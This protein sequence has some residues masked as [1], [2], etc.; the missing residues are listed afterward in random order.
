[1]DYDEAVE[2]FDF[3]IAAAYVGPGTPIFME[4]VREE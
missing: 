1:M 3:N 2:F 4:P